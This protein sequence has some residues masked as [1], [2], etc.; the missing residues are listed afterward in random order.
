MDYKFVI[1]L[2][3]LL[4]LIFL[5]V[6]EMSNIRET[7]NESFEKTK[8]L[9]GISNKNSEQNLKKGFNSCIDR[10][11]LINGDYM[12]QI[13]KMSE[14]GREI[15]TTNSNNYSDSD[16]V[17][18][19]TKNKIIYLSEEMEKKRPVDNFKINFSD[20]KNSKGSKQSENSK[21]EQVKKL[22]SQ[23]DENKVSQKGSA[24]KETEKEKSDSTSNESRTSSAN[25]DNTDSS[26]TST[27]DSESYSEELSSDNGTKIDM[28][29][30]ESN[31]SGK[32]TESKHKSDASKTIT[33]S[34]SKKNNK[35]NKKHIENI[36]DAGS[37]A[38]SDI[39]LTL[40]TLKEIDEYNIE[41]LKKVA[42]QFGIPITYKDKESDTRK[43]Y[44]KAVL[45]EKIKNRL[46]SVSA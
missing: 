33:T 16:S 4:G 44:T 42:K 31:E 45:Y 19:S 35:K 17:K 27:N 8:L 38:T 12:V 43:N 5:I 7:V 18:K 2:S 20:E 13:R 22:S 30:L 36:A 37:I 32:S 3:I 24:R 40:D 6:K 1:I 26:N 14:I 21:E 11:K 10:I 25:T 9:I 23:K 46:N 39:A 41:Y 15:I 29:D 28:D 34:S